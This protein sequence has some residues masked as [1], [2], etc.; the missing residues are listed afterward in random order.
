M[1][2]ARVRLRVARVL[3]RFCTRS[4]TG[5]MENEKMQMVEECGDNVRSWFVALN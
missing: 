5:C 1:A 4:R 2:I 3:R